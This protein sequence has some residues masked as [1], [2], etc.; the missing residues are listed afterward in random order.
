MR[1]MINPGLNTEYCEVNYNLKLEDN[2]TNI[3]NS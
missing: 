1:L 2:K 3:E